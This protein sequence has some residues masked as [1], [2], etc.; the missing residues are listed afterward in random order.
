VTASPARGDRRLTRRRLIGGGLTAAAAIVIGGYELVDHGELPGKHTLDELDGACSVDIPHESFVATGPTVGGRFYSHARQR[1]VGYSIAYPPE[2]RPGDHLPLGLFLH[3]DGSNHTT[4][5]G[6]LTPARALA[7]DGIAPFAIATFD[8]GNLYWNPH[9]GDDPMAMIVNE[10]VPMCR[11]RGLGRRHGT[12]AAIGVSMG[13]F[14]ALLLAEKHPDLVSSVAAISPA[15][16]TSYAQAAAVNPS[17]F[18]SAVD[19][20]RD[21]II[22]HAGAVARIP[23]RIASGADD[24]FHSGVVSLTRRLGSNATV[25]VTPGCHDSAFFTSQ[26]QQSLRFLAQHFAA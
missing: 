3:P 11:H 20:A 4:P 12:V 8:G 21:D 24:P 15:V 2:H 9:P 5:L 1:E 10:I 16:W 22:A 26:Q 13:G 19:F 18:A 6:R 7:G 14:G 17:A 25:D 23:V